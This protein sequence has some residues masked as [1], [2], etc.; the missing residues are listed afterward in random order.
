MK[1][2]KELTGHGHFLIRDCHAGISVHLLRDSLCANL[3]IKEIVS[4]PD[5]AIPL[6]S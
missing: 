5:S 3:E 6:L 1:L 4:Y 2:F